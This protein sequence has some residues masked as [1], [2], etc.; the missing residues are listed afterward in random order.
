VLARVCLSSFVCCRKKSDEVREMSAI[1]IQTVWRK[2]K[3]YGRTGANRDNSKS[4]SKS[5]RPVSRGSH[6]ESKEVLLRMEQ[7][8]LMRTSPVDYEQ[9][10]SA[11]VESKVWDLNR[12]VEEL[13]TEVQTQHENFR[14]DVLKE[15]ALIQGRMVTS[16]LKEVRQASSERQKV[17]QQDN[18]GNRSPTAGGKKNGGKKP[19]KKSAGDSGGAGATGNVFA[20]MAVAKKRAAPVR[21]RR[22]SRD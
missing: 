11:R 2:M 15:M 9:D 21:S 13:K 22:L 12:E 16:L 19:P 14:K 7:L 20:T 8:K 5:K 17:Q 3:E 6:A 10:F 1:A 4:K 18:S